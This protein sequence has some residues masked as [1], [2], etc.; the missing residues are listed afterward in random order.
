MPNLTIRKRYIGDRNALIG[1]RSF[2]TL[3]AP[4]GLVFM[5]GYLLSN[6]LGRF[7][8]PRWNMIAPEE[9]ERVDVLYG[10]YLRDLSRQLDR[11]DGRGAH[12]TTRLRFEVERAHDGIQRALRRVRARRRI[13]GLSGVGISRRPLRQRRAGSRWPRI[14]RTATSHPMQYYTVSA[15]A[16]GAVSRGD[17]RRDAGD[18]RGVRYRSAG[19]TAR[20]VRRQ[21]RRDRPHDSEP[22]E[23]ARR[24]CVH[25]LARSRSIRQRVAQR[26]RQRESHVHARCARQRSVVRAGDRRWRRLQRARRLRSRRATREEQHVQ[27][28]ATLRTTRENGWNGSLVYSQYD[29][30]EDSTLQA[31]N[32]D[33]V[34][35]HRRQRDRTRERDGTG[36]QTFEAQ[37]VYAPIANDWTGGAHTLALGYHQNEY[38]L[39]NPVYDTSD[40]RNRTGVLGQDVFGETRL[41]AVYV[42]DQWAT[43]PTL[44]AD[45]RP[46]LRGLVRVRRRAARRRSRDRLPRSLRN[47]P[48]TESIAR[49]HAGR[50]TGRCV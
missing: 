43:R 27:W 1:G 16:N 18:R 37:G 20:R 4:R 3:Q 8:A 29:I 34:A 49:V 7:D 30:R 50:S 41:R 6:F 31:N 44:V 42:Q 12:A 21:C 36:W 10:P 38:Q 14:T 26:D 15:N 32:P 13:L 46:A 17:R 22:G 9:I 5:D 39:R 11:H 40:W 47:R 48:L 33:P 23:A 28:G 45:A 19:S 2:S 25:R 24:L 35:A